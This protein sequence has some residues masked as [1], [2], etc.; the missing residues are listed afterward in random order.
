MSSEHLRLYTRPRQGNLEET[1]LMPQEGTHNQR[2]MGPQRT[3]H[4]VHILT[5]VIHST[6]RKHRTERECGDSLV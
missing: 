2:G 6:I 5:S 1:E 4:Q 3:D